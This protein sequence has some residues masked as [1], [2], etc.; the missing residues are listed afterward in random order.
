MTFF[1]IG[2][3]PVEGDRSALGGDE[4]GGGFTGRT[5]GGSSGHITVSGRMVVS[6]A[7]CKYVF[8]F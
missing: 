6:Y 5:V 3:V 8:S 4:G 7:A 1:E 2:T